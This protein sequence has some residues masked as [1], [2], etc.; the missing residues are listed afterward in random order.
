M[1]APL[2][3][4]PA[5]YRQ[6]ADSRRPFFLITDA[7]LVDAFVIDGEGEVVAIDPDRGLGAT[8][9]GRTADDA[10]VLVAAPGSFLGPLSPGELGSRRVMTLPCGSTPVTLDHLRAALPVLEETDVG[11]QDQ[12][13][14]AFFAAVEDC[15]DMTITDQERSTAGVFPVLADYGEWHQQAGPLS[16]GEQQIAPSGELSVLAGGIDTFDPDVTLPLSGEVTLRG[17]VIVHA[18][19]DAS[20]IDEQDD[21]YRRLAPLYRAPVILGVHNGVIASCRPGDD[22]A[23]AAGTAAEMER[24]LESDAGYRT[25]WEIGF[26]INS[27]LGL[28]PGNCGLNEVFGGRYGTLHVGLGLT[29]GTRFALTFLCPDSTVTTDAGQRIAGKPGRRVTRVRSASCG[30][31]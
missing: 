28:L 16:P 2:A 27:E 6:F 18:G 29:P 3:V 21:L 24:L 19:Y 13:A 11:T 1:T 9:T 8:L 17:P 10:D 15:T 20:L 31:H 5:R 30:C 22:S 4:R 12:R 7:E 25:V 23:S 26:G 14:A